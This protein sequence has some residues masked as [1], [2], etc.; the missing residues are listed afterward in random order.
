[1]DPLGK[2]MSSITDDL[3][4]PPTLSQASDF[5]SK[6]IKFKGMIQYLKKK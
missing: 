4:E 5:F 3:K 2:T 6:I 1:M